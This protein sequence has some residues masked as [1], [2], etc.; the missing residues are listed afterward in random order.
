VPLALTAKV[1]VLTGGPGCGKWGLTTSR[2]QSTL[3]NQRY[4]P[5]NRSRFGQLATKE[6]PTRRSCS[7]SRIARNPRSGPTD[8]SHTVRHQ[9]PRLL[10]FAAYLDAVDLCGK[11]NVPAVPVTLHSVR[12]K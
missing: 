7:A 6:L 11:D 1:A 8:H 10:N 5:G 9:S 4:C 12:G 2:R 3:G